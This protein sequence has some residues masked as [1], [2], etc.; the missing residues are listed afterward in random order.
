MKKIPPTKETPMTTIHV[1]DHGITPDTD[2]T[3]ALYDLFR[4]F[5]KDTAFVFED[6][7]YYFAPHE[8][9][10][11]DYRL[12]NSDVMPYRVLGLWLKDM[13]NIVLQGNHTRLYFAGQ[14]QP[15][16]MDG[17]RHICMKDFVIDWKK[18]LVAEGTV[19]GFG[20][21]Y[22]YLYIDPDL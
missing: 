22:A 17:C 18:P 10:H 12:S 21:G 20:E 14:M 6:A 15:V 5:P 8:E 7:E 3:L 11:A 9:M 19:V 13:E 16:T 2:C 4:R 1:K